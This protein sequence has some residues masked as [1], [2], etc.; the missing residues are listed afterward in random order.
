MG[1]AEFVLRSHCFIKSDIEDWKK[2]RL[3]AYTMVQAPYLDPKKIPKTV[4]L[5]MPLPE[6]KANQKK[7]ID[8]NQAAFTAALEKYKKEVGKS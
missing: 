4:E 6:D 2:I 7:V 1:W 5:F 8:A 3:L